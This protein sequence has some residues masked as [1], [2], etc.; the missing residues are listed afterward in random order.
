MS[1]KPNP[2]DLPGPRFV[3]PKSSLEKQSAMLV[4]LV[5]DPPEN[6][7]VVTITPELAQ[8][9]LDNRHSK[10]RKRKPARIKRY[11]PPV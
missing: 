3:D 11:W 7:R 10:N 8:W 4:A 9:V 5:K 1:T 6:S 2:V